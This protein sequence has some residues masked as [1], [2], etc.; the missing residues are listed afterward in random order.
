MGIHLIQA[1]D[2]PVNTVSDQ[3]MTEIAVQNG[4][5]ATLH[6]RHRRTGDDRHA[7]QLCG[8]TVLHVALPDIHHIL[9]YS[10]DASSPQPPEEELDQLGCWAAEDSMHETIMQYLR[11]DEYGKQAVEAIILAEFDRCKA[12][13]SLFPAS[14]FKLNLRIRK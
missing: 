1:L 7:Q 8:L 10:D 11:L 9:G 2:T 13:E 14:N 3:E 6:P 4:H 5:P 12:Q